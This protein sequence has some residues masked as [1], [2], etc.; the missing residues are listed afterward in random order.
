MKS[1]WTKRRIGDLCEVTS[2]RRTYAKDHV[3]KGIP[4]YRSKEV[5]ERYNGRQVFTTDLFITE[6]WYNEIKTNFGVPLVGDVLLT[7]RGSLGVPYVVRDTKPFYFADGNL[8]WFRKLKGLDSTFLFYWFL[9]PGGTAELKKCTIGSSQ[10][11]YTIVL[12]KEMSIRL[13]SLPTQRK[14]ASILSAYDDLMENNTRRISVLEAMVQAIYREWFVEFRF[15]GHESATLVNSPLGKIPAGWK[16]S[17]LGDLAE[18]VR[19]GVDPSQV[20]PDTP[21]FGLEHLP[22]KSITLCEWGHA[23]DV[24]STKRAFRKGDILF[25]KIRPYFHKVGVAPVDGICSSDAIVISPKSESAFGPVLCCVSSEVFVNHATQTSQGTKMPRANWDVLVKYASPI[26]QGQLLED[27]NGTISNIVG[28]L[29]L[30]M[31]KNRNLRK[32]R[33]LLLPNLISGQLDVEDLDIDTG[34]AGTE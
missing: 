24:Q 10:Q 30:L 25:G 3:T 12:L 14:T 17:H 21:Y 27:F 9:S 13:P 26:P 20:D 19:R 31:L 32:T 28:S 18:E 23:R 4:F 16:P 33:D 34:E 11:A 5:I 22:R 8:T 7:S 15:P 1:R 6:A 29:R 2:S